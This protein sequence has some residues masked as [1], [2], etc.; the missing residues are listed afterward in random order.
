MEMGLLYPTNETVVKGNG[1]RFTKVLEQKKGYK[2]WTW[3]KSCMLY[4]NVI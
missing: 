3:L 4:S 1:R 2:N